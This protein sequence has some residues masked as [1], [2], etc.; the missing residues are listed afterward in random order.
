MSDGGDTP[1]WPGQQ[2]ADFRDAVPLH[3][4]APSNDLLEQLEHVFAAT[5]I[6]EVWAHY[7]RKM[8]AH[9]FDRLLYAYTRFPSGGGFGDPEDAL[10]VSSMPEG[11]MRRYIGEGLFRD[12]PTA[13]WLARNEG[14]L[15]WGEINDRYSRGDLT[16]AQM[17][18][19][20]HQNEF[21]IIHGFSI[22]FTAPAPRA[23]ATMGICARAGLDQA[24]A[25]EIWRRDRR[26]LMVISSATHLRLISL[27]QEF[28]GHQLTARQREVLQWVGEG[29]TV[30]D[31]ATILGVTPATVEK[32]LR[33]ARD[34]LD[35]QTTAQAVLKAAFRNQLYT[36]TPPLAR[37]RAKRW[38]G[39]R[40]W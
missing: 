14:L 8:A 15:N 20:E 37:R 11:F 33:L 7:C 36:V 28:Y 23:L 19:I 13:Q 30:Q 1:G 4:R 26:E 31:T 35:V 18:A 2:L 25:D 38:Q 29:K 3:L 17:R 10:I 24:D 21:G 5:S 39:K 12:C 40:S 16:A 6:E 34:A 22:G 27:P 32:H 9:G